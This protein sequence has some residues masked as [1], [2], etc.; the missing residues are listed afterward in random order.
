VS[1]SGKTTLFNIAAG[2]LRPSS[3]QVV[4]TQAA[5]P[6]IDLYA[7]GEAA[8]DRFRARHIGYIFQTH[9]LLPALTARENVAM[10]MVFAGIDR[11][12]HARRAR[13]LLE[14]VG[15]GEYEQVLPRRL[16]TG[17]RLR[18]AAARALANDPAVLLA[19][20]PTAALDADAA[21]RLLALLRETCARNQAIL[22]VASHDPALV[23]AF[24]RVID[25]RRGRLYPHD[26]PQAAPP[27]AAPHRTPMQEEA[28]R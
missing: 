5:G 11:R 26:A 10:P 25:L 19:D 18:V 16:S 13:A 6:A 7:L 2:L 28:S 23:D 21:A 14:A 22:L 17:Q 15:L 8:R 9:H 24:D 1:G 12:E 4:Y 3:G 27:D 20:E